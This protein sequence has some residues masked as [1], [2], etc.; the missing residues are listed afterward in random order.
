[1]KIVGE[2]ADKLDGF[3]LVNH[4]WVKLGQISFDDSW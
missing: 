4:Q 3:S 2:Q 1:M